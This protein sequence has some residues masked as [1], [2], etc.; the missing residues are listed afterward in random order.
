MPFGEEIQSGTGGRNSAQGYGGGDSIRQK[1]TSY[2]RDN[3]NGLDF[4]QNRYYSSSLGRFTSVDPALPSM[5]VANP[6]TFNRYTYCLNN[7]L[8]YVDPDGLEPLKVLTWDKLTE[9]QKRLFQ[10][11]VEANYAEQLKNPLFT[12]EG[13]WNESAAV[14][15][16][17]AAA[18]P[19]ARLL[20]QAQLT[21]FLAVTNMLENGPHGNVIGELVS[22]T[23]INGNTGD[24]GS[25]FNIRGEL[26]NNTTSVAIMKK[27]F[28][29]NIKGKG[30]GTYEE[31]NR[32]Q[33][34]N[35]Q[36]NGQMT[37]IP[38]TAKVEIDI[39]YRAL[40][41]II[42]HNTLENADIRADD[43]DTSHYRR[44]V[45]R[46]GPIRALQ[47]AYKTYQDYRRAQDLIRAGRRR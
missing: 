4:A 8:S 6:Q 14:A 9:D 1:F 24:G 37:R 33:G 38:G 21:T 23:E 44:H 28:D 15:N 27:F 2:E 45:E 46:Y 35:G 26:K 39:D 10:T 34:V 17:E 11:Y 22:V 32:E 13:L 25:D 31:S 5:D 43:G 47:P 20:D 12:A 19:N 16:S 3:E 30:H 29:W 41:R 40:R 18:G 42:A 7:P 36:P